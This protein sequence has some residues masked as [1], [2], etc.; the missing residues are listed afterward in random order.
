[1]D[2]IGIDI[3]KRGSPIYVLAE[4]GEVIEQRIRAEP[5]RF[6]ALLGPGPRRGCSS[7]RLPPAR[8]R[9]LLFAVADRES[10]TPCGV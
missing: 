7:R 8:D 6:A 2:D 10:N 4:G 1:M 5:E 3:P 9:Q